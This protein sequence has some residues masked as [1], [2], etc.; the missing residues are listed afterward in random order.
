M[1][2]PWELRPAEVVLGYWKEVLMIEEDAIL[3]DPEYV[4]VNP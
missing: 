4:E 1:I 2:A 3:F